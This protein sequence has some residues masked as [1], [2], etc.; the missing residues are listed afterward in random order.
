MSSINIELQRSTH[1]IER[2]DQI[3]DQILTTAATTHV[4]KPPNQNITWNDTE[5]TGW[6]NIFQFWLLTTTSPCCVWTNKWTQ[7]LIGCHRDTWLLPALL[8]CELHV[9]QRCK[10]EGSRSTTSQ[11]IPWCPTGL[12]AVHVTVQGK[13]ASFT[14]MPL[15]LTP[16]RTPVY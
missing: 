10:T 8:S 5:Y 14:Q 1:L 11:N 7:C 3:E 6:H 2:K 4:Y 15:N 12:N 9:V 16:P 13:L